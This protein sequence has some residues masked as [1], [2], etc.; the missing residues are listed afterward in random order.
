MYYLIT[1][2]ENFLH[3]YYS[4]CQTRGH[5]KPARNPTGTGAGAEMHPRV[6]LRAGFA[7]P[8]GF[9]CGRVFAEAACGCHP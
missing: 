3:F 1:Q 6:Y 8:R 2:I 7:Q 5:L 4:C 9:D